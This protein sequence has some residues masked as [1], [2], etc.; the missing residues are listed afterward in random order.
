MSKIYII[1][2]VRNVSPYVTQILDDYVQEQEELHGN[3]VHYPPRDVDQSDPN[4]KEITHLLGLH[5][6]WLQV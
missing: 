2:P 4:G 6:Y 5:V 3:V 1:C